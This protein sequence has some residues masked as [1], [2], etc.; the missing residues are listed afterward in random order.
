MKEKFVLVAMLAML[1]FVVCG[2]E[3]EAEDK[4]PTPAEVRHDID[5]GWQ[6]VVNHEAYWARM[7]RLDQEKVQKLWPQVVWD[8]DYENTGEF[9]KERATADGLVA[10]ANCMA[11]NQ[12]PAN[13]GWAMIKIGKVTGVSPTHDNLMEVAKTL[14]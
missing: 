5:T 11:G 1:A 14:Y 6:R 13:F 4:K 2:C 10:W 8:T 12:P 3:D 9:V 7:E